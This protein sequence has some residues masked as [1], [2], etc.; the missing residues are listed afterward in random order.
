MPAPGTFGNSSC[1]SL[2]GLSLS[3]FDLT[4]SER[5]AITE[6]PGTE[7][8]AEI[9]N[10]F[11][12]ANFAN[13]ANLRLAQGLNGLQPGDAVFSRHRRGQLRSRRIHRVQPDRHRHRPP[14]SALAPP[15]LLANAKLERPFS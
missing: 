13:P 5:F 4:L 9:Y 1:N 10:I 3:Q 7:F 15:E 12:N 6:R 8:R 11:N 14:D 2:T